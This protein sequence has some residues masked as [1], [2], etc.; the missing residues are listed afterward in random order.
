ML[1]ITGRCGEDPEKDSVRVGM[2]Q[3]TGPEQKKSEGEV[4][5]SP[6]QGVKKVVCVYRCLFITGSE[7]LLE[8]ALPNTD[9][10]W[11]LS[12]E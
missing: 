10:K 5:R 6:R 7:Q 12:P 8:K 1:A 4:S 3:M 2:S 11:L 9:Y